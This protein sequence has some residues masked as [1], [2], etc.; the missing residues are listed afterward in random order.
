MN[1]HRCQARVLF[2][3]LNDAI[4][5]LTEVEGQVAGFVE[6]QEGLFQEELVFVLEGQRESIYDATGKK[7][8]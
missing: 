2:D 5:K 4:I 1:D 3:K 6:G 8:Y 7:K